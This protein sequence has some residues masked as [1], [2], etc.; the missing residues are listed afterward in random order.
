M[1]VDGKQE[2]M[3]NPNMCYPKSWLKYCE[4]NLFWNGPLNLFNV[5]FFQIFKLVENMEQYV[6]ELGNIDGKI[7][8][9]MFRL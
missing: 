4:S 3:V 6:Y 9:L 7:C 1:N 5:F 8:F 2:S